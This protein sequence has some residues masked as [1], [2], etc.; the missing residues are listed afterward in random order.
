MKNFTEESFKFCVSKLLLMSKKLAYTSMLSGFILGLLVISLQVAG[1]SFTTVLAQES[2]IESI[3]A[4]ESTTNATEGAAVPATP[5]P[6]A[7]SVETG[8][9]FAQQGTVTSTQDPLPG[10]EAHQLAILLPPR[11]DG[12]IYEGTVTYTASK[13][14]EVVVLQN[15]A[16]NTAVDSFYGG[17]ATAPLGEGTVAISL[18]SPQYSGP[19]NAAS[20]PFA[21]N[22]LALHTI[23]GDPFAATYTVTGDVLQ[24][25]TFDSIVPAPIAAAQADAGQTAEE[26]DGDEDKKDKKDKKDNND[27]S[28][29]G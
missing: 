13:P 9:S 23:N 8:G 5:E 2:E 7:S 22:A 21:G 20:L 4:I 3:S 16:N 15:F 11:A 10:H 18:I 27:D 24:A 12:S 1:F 25:E 28:A 6:K 19:I 29:S 14:V 26:K 17:L